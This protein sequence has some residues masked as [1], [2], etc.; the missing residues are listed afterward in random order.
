MLSVVQMIAGVDLR[1]PLQ[2]EDQAAAVHLGHFAT[3]S[4]LGPYITGML[5]GTGTEADP[6][7]SSLEMS[8]IVRNAAAA[9]LARKLRVTRQTSGPMT[10]AVKQPPVAR[11]KK[12]W[13]RFRAGVEITSLLKAEVFADRSAFSALSAVLNNTRQTNSATQ[14]LYPYVRRLPNASKKH[15]LT[16]KL[17]GQGGKDGR[18][19]DLGNGF[20]LHLSD[21]NK[22]AAM[23]AHSKLD[24]PAKLQAAKHD[25]S[26]FFKGH[27]RRGGLAGGHGTVTE[28]AVRNGA[29]RKNAKNHLI[30]DDGFPGSGFMD[31]LLCN[32][33]NV[34]GELSESKDLVAVTSVYLT[35]DQ[36]HGDSDFVC[37]DTEYKHPRSRPQRGAVSQSAHSIPQP[38]FLYALLASPVDIGHRTHSLCCSAVL[39]SPVCMLLVNNS[40]SALGLSRR[41]IGGPAQPLRAGVGE[42][43][44]KVGGR[45]HGLGFRTLA[46]LALAPFFQPES[47]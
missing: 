15:F 33:I 7:I 9:S 19:L 39:S 24:T 4:V 38:G 44:A 47:A 18:W 28:A 13:H 36:L 45:W 35:P 8:N 20:G 40:I 22:A 6:G 42:P 32:H 34:M 17:K 37:I 14:L 25:L 43:G 2:F 26:V 10:S 23:A 31:H 12:E 21:E 11:D 46:Q 41:Q 27:S 3:R 29:A 5:D 30:G 16:A 1:T